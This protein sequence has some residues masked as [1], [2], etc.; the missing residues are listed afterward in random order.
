MLQYEKTHFVS[1]LE[2]IVLYLFQN[3]FELYFYH[4]F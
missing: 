2:P 4:D 3:M 1:E